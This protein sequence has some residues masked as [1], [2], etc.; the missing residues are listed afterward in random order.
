LGST[1]LVSSHFNNEFRLNYSSNQ[2]SFLGSL[3]NFGGATP[4]DLAQLQGISP[5]A[6][7]PYQMDVELNFPGFTPQDIYQTRVLAEQRQWNAVD[8]VSLPMGRHQWRI[9]VDYRRIA[10]IQRSSNPSVTYIFDTSDSV[11]TNSVD[12]AIARS[13][14]AAYPLYTNVSMFGQDQ[15]RVNPRLSVSLGLRWDINPA[16]GAVKGNRPYTVQGTSLSTLQLAPQGTPLWDTS[17][18]SFAPRLGVAYVM[19]NVAGQETVVRGGFGV[20]FDT[21]QQLGSQG[22]NGPGFFSIVSYV[23]P[24]N[25][26][27]FPMSVEQ[28]EPPIVN[29]PVPPYG[30]VYAFPAHLQAPFTLQ[31]NATIDQAFG[32]AQKLTISYV[33]ANGRKLL[34]QTRVLVGNYNPDFGAVFFFKN[35]HTSDYDAL[36]VQ[37][38]RQLS[39]GLQALASYTWAHSIDYGSQNTD[40]PYI[41]GNSSLDIRH[42]FSTAFSYDLPGH[43]QYRFARALFGGWGLD[44]RFTARTGFPVTL[45]GRFS[46]DPAT[47]QQMPAGLNLIPNQPLYV[48]GPNYPG[49]RAINVEAFQFAAPSTV[50]NAPRNFVRGF[51]AWQMDVAL[52]REFS[53]HDRLKLQF[54]AESFNVFNHPNFGQVNPFLC[55]PGPFCTFGQ[56]QQ[57]LAQSLGV[58]SPLY[59]MGGPRS[60]QFAIKL[61]F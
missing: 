45:N 59:Q 11:Q 60:M 27:R 53:I 42:N 15:W 19:R 46:F 10:P 58:L 54:R 26:V 51:G 9:G 6:N 13:S 25:P 61:M 52:R 14:A 16:P 31:W 43:F 33:G 34:E 57:T 55:P 36:Q 39:H 32:K 8:T 29:P 30:T 35:G 20:F 48:Y 28:A 21:G 2:S 40:Y 41:R 7:A 56:A 37:F 22:Y 5:G 23:P 50:G 24:D 17:W 49:G 1:A 4:V 12:A 18:H 47:G 38:Q 3:D 44:D